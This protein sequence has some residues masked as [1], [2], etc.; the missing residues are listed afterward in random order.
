VV[1][2]VE[3][4]VSGVALAALLQGVAELNEMTEQL[5][6]LKSAF[7]KEEPK[8]ARQIGW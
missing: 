8:V 5:N 4:Q 2:T 6:K 1:A 3:R 7:K